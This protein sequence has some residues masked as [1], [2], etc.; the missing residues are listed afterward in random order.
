LRR[1]VQYPINLRETKREYGFSIPDQREVDDYP[2]LARMKATGKYDKMQ[3]LTTFF[4]AKPRWYLP[5]LKDSI[6]AC[7]NV[8][9]W[10]YVL[11]SLA[12]LGYLV[13]VSVNH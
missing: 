11:L 13:Y 3:G 5:A 4:I 8:A 12:C 10:I 1:I 7:D 2:E 9:F 6:V